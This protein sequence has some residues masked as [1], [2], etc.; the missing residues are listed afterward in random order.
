MT[1]IV[2]VKIPDGLVLAGDSLATVMG[3]LEGRLNFETDCPHC[4]KKVKGQ[5]Q[6]PSLNLP[7]TS[8]SFA[9]KILQFH[10][11]FGIGAYG[12]G[13]VGGRTIYYA[14]RELEKE[15]E[16]QPPNSTGDAAQL[17]GNRLFELLKDEVEGN[18]KK[19][20]DQPDAWKPVGIQIL[21]YDEKVPKRFGVRIGKK[22]EIK[23][24]SDHEILVTGQNEVF[25]AL[26]GIYKKNPQSEPLVGAFSLQDA[27]HYVDFLIRT[28]ALHQQFSRQIPSVGGEIDIALLTP[29]D[30]FSWIHKKS[31]KE[32]MD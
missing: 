7:A 6:I 18:G 31:L 3:G 12:A 16:G 32:R 17:I 10:T 14:L 5:V 30:Q 2:S 8:F 15:T 21:G 27:I 1:L 19:I 24:V 4:R 11:R 13:Q 23:D 25:S 28:T 22:V 26:A 20:E 9:R 29:F